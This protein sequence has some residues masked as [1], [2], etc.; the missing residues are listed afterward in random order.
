MKVLDVSVYDW[1]TFDAQCFAANDVGRLIV[2]TSNYEVAKAMVKQAREA[3]IIV[4]DLYGF[5]YYGLGWESRDLDNCI[6]LTQELGGFQRIWLDCES[7]FS[8]NGVQDDTEAPGITVQYRVMRTREQRFRVET[9][10][11]DCGIYTG[12]FWWPSKMGNTTEF[13]DLPLWIANYGTNDPDNP[14][15][16]ITEVN[17]GG[18][19]KVAAHQYSSTIGLC[20]RSVRDNNYWFLEDSLTDRDILA[21]F[22][23]TER[24]ANDELDYDARLAAAKARYEE[25]IRTGHSPFDVAA[26]AISDAEKALKLASAGGGAAGTKI[27]AHTHTQPPTTGPVS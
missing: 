11:L 19:T 24:D 27:P 10:G 22:G 1:S 26:Q 12:A 13:S 2:G 4:E 16:P 21:I 8:D 18:W 15:S 9:N 6:K 25:S 7:G 3:G 20:G 14:R 17:F 23:S 5:I